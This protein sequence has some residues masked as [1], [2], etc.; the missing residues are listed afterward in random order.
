MMSSKSWIGPNDEA[1]IVPK[2]DG[3]GIMISAF[4][5]H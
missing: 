3:L 1:N 4:Q 5:L 2:N